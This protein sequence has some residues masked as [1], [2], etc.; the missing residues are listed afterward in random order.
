LTELSKRLD[1]EQEQHQQVEQSLED[2]KLE[3]K[4]TLE[5]LDKEQQQRQQLEQSFEKEQLKKSTLPLFEAEADSEQ[6]ILLQPTKAYSIKSV[7]SGKVLYIPQG[8]LKNNMPISQDSWRGGQNQQWYF[9]PLGGID[10]GYY[11][12]FSARSKKCLNVSS[13]VLKDN[14]EVQQYRCQGEDNQKWKL[15]P[16]PGGSFMIQSKQSEKVLTVSYE[17]GKIVQ[18][19]SDEADYQRWFLNEV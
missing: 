7:S 17:L 3:L 10:Q 2:T 12:I 16:A 15:V 1:H 13:K 9:Q 14:T 11:Y 19:T 4:A 18:Y 5:K 8:S 6:V